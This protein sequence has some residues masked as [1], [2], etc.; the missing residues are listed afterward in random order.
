VPDSPERADW[1]EAHAVRAVWADLGLP[2]AIDIHTHFMPANVMTK[3]WRYFDGADPDR[4]W[5]ITYRMAERDRLDRLREFGIV[6][7]TSLVYPHKP[8]MADWLNTWSRE[9]A[10]RTPDCLHTATFYPE[11]EAAEYVPVAIEA[12]ARIFK[13]HIQVG[14]YSPNDPL[15]EPVWGTIEDAGIPVVTHAGSGPTPA[16]F[17]GPAQIA[18]LLKRHPRLRLVIAHMGMPEYS[19][20]LDLVDRYP[21]LHLDTTMVFTDFTERLAPFPPDQYGRLSQI[22]DRILL[23]TDFPNIPYPYL[24]GVTALVDLDLGD[25]W[26]RDVL[27]YNAKRLLS[28]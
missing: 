2:G 17:T 15:L 20:F 19:E 21:D 14:N 28:L 12:G 4:P 25:A 5:P 23:G 3:V 1:R 26:L 6:A 18:G 24:E 27:Y 7:F 10:E 9:F 22:R 16:R 11:P 13:A 8:G